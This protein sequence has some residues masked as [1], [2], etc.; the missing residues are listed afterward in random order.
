MEPSRWRWRPEAF[1][2][3]TF[4]DADDFIRHLTGAALM[5]IGGVLAMGCT[6]GQGMT[7]LSTLALSSLLTFAAILAGGAVGIRQLERALR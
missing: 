2:S 7:G 6:I 3:E 1:V 4:T 5:G